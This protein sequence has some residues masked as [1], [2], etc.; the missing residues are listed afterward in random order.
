M[1]AC[2]L[3][4]WR[5]GSV[6]GSRSEGWALKLLWGPFAG[7]SLL[8]DHTQKGVLAPT[9]F[10]NS[11]TDTVSERLRKWIRNPLCSASGGL[12]PF[13]VAIPLLISHSHKATIGH[14]RKKT[15][16]NQPCI[17]E[18]LHRH[19]DRVVKVLDLKSSGL[20]PQGFK[21]PR[22]RLRIVVHLKVWNLFVFI[23][24]HFKREC[25]R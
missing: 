3:A 17:Q 1:K 21:P 4:P 16:N 18:L 15:S 11:G 20:S 22:C 9:I 7:F 6:S 13:G 10:V 25:V 19:C 23:Q 14:T 24:E 12:N 5:N 2:L 8:L